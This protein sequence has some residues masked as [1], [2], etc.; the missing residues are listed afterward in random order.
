M[1]F[2]SLPVLLHKPKL[3]TLILRSF[4]IAPP[5]LTYLDTFRELKRL[6]KQNERIRSEELMRKEEEEKETKFRKIVN[7][8]LMPLTRGNKFMRDFY[9]GRY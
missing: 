3:S 4:G 7:E 8:R 1:Q 5:S 9:S 6:Q 2:S